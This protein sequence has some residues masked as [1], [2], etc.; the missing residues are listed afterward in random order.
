M[1]TNRYT[2]IDIQVIKWL[3]HLYRLIGLRIISSNLPVQ[4][5][6][7]VVNQSSSSAS[8]SIVGG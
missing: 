5:H 1:Q 7:L 6:I 2:I 8:L 3:I 4:W